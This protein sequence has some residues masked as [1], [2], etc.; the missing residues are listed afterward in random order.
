MPRDSERQL[1]TRNAGAVV[2][3][4]N[5]FDSAALEPDIDFRRTRV[6]TVLEQFLDHRRWALDDFAGGDLADQ[7]ISQRTNCA[8]KR[9]THGRDYMKAA[10]AIAGSLL[11]YDPA[12]LAPLAPARSRRCNC[13]DGRHQL[14][15]SVHGDRSLSGGDR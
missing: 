11:T 13:S 2:R 6:K 7:R 9:G 3:H 15:R 1:I 10:P 8:T 12:L 5:A 14:A 4:N